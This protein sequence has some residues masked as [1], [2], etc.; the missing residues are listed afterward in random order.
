MGRTYGTD[1]LAHIESLARLEA[2]PS[3]YLVQ[4]LNDLRNSGLIQSKRGKQ[5]GY[6]LA[7][8]PES[9]TLRDIIRAIDPE[10]IDA[11]PSA[12]GESGPGVEAV[13]PGL[14]QAFDD[15]A[16]RATLRDCMASGGPP[17]YFI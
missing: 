2:V 8:A 10:M 4:I 12:S 11:H 15:A 7:S 13:W 14:S 16:I 17:M 6:A 9:I 3:N 5:G 1:T